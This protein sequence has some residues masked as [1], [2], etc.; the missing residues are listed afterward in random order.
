MAHAFEVVFV[1]ESF[2]RER[3]KEEPVA[4]EAL[5]DGVDEE[6]IRRVDDEGPAFVFFDFSN[7]GEQKVEEFHIRSGGFGDID[8]DLEQQ[9]KR[10]TNF[11]QHERNGENGKNGSEDVERIGEM[12][13][14][15]NH[16]QR[17]NAE[18]EDDANQVWY[19]G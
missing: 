14:A 16:A 6:M 19:R 15:A 11:R 3:T 17:V 2:K 13:G 5:D 18:E 9:V 1:I 7:A 8:G 10:V 4:S 12:S